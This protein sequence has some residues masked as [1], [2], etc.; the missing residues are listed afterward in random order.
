MFVETE[1][2]FC[3]DK[4][5]LVATRMT[6]VA[7]PAS[8]TYPLV[9]ELSHILSYCF[10]AFSVLVCWTGYVLHKAFDFW[11]IVL[12]IHYTSVLFTSSC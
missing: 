8:D 2:V 4:S 11:F 9:V 3:R 1:H 7:A 6:L 5:M 10:V 12:D